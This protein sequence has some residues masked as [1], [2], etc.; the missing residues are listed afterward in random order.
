[1]LSL[2]SV[3][4]FSAAVR[5]NN[6]ELHNTEKKV[7]FATVPPLSPATLDMIFCLW[8]PLPCLPSLSPQ[9]IARILHFG[10]A[11][12]VLKKPPRSK[13]KTK[14]SG[15]WAEED[16][17]M[18]GFGDRLL[19]DSSCRAWLLPFHSDQCQHDTTA[20]HPVTV[21]T[22]QP[23]RSALRC[24]PLVTDSCFT[25]SLTAASHSPRPKTHHMQ[26]PS[27]H[28]EGGLTS[29]PS[30][31]TTTSASCCW[32]RPGCA[33][34]VTRPRSPTWVLGPLLSPLQRK[35][36]GRRFRHKVRG[37]FWHDFR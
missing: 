31:R 22:S 30:F 25:F 36:R 21:T 5:R 8:K 34:P 16:Q 12:K 2:R 35:R 6:R 27:A 7:L 11:R 13:N 9:L 33:L 3:T 10:I 17:V 18:V 28:P 23:P 26:D 1:M 32:R 4:A 29:P 24:V 37:D 20:L 14:T 19:P 15:E